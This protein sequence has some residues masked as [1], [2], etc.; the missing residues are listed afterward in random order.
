MKIVNR[1]MLLQEPISTVY[2]AWLPNSYVELRVMTGL[3]PG[4]EEWTSIRLVNNVKTAFFL[5]QV[6][7]KSIPQFQPMP[8]E[9]RSEMWL[10]W[11][12]AD[13][14][15]MLA[16]MTAAAASLAEAAQQHFG[17]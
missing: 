11:E 14:D 2:S 4:G 13:I 15:I 9:S 17:D 8:G 16:R 5:D 1:R 12:A 3:C 7:V 6:F 10:V